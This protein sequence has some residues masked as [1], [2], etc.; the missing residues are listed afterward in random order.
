M[1][2]GTSK[3]S[4]TFGG[5]AERSEA[6]SFSD[7]QQVAL[8]HP[9]YELRE[10]RAH[11]TDHKSQNKADEN[12]DFHLIT[13]SLSPI[14]LGFFGEL[15]SGT[16]SGAASEG[17]EGACPPRNQA[18][19][20]SGVTHEIGL[21]VTRVDMLL[22]VMSTN[23]C[24]VTIANA[25]QGREAIAAAGQPP[26]AEQPTVVEDWHIHPC[27]TIEEDVAEVESQ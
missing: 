12:H 23:L 9:R 13:E 24:L 11:F 25:A 5:E 19:F 14:S 15:L 26:L 7:V 17:A 16:S 22:S 18:V 1:A 3:R 20:P 4:R 2:Q 8:R 21:T 10:K 27:W 6:A